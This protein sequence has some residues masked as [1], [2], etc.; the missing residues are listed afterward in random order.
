MSPTC[1]L[2][3]NMKSCA[4]LHWK[5]LCPLHVNSVTTWSHVWVFIGRHYVPYMSTLLQH[6]V[7]CESSLEDIMSP[8]CQLCY[9]MKSCVS[10]HWKTLCPLPVNSAT[11]W[12]HV[13]VFIGRHMSP[14]CQLCY[15][16]KSC[17]SLHWKT[18]CPLPVNSATTWSHVWVFIGRHYVPYLSTLLQHEVMCESSL[19]DIMSPTC[20]LCYNMKSCRTQGLIHFCYLQGTFFM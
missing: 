6:E 7:M 17:V 18:L 15:N 14:T 2:C 9:N 4:S 8:T 13:W 3:Y 1:Q 19:E 11:T 20:Q 16:M 10:L 12:S 5:T